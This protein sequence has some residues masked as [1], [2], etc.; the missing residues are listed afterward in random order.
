MITHRI[1]SNSVE[2]HDEVSRSINKNIEGSSSMNE[3]IKLFSAYS[4]VDDFENCRDVV[5][6]WFKCGSKFEGVDYKNLIEG[7][8][9]FN[10]QQRS[11][12]ESHVDEYFTESE[13]RL[14]KR[15]LKLEYDTELIIDDQVLPMKLLKEGKGDVFSYWAISS[16][17]NTYDLTRD[18][19]GDLPF[20]VSGFYN[21][22]LFFPSK[23]LPFTMKHAGL[24]FLWRA[25]DMLYPPR[26]EIDF[27]K[28]R[29]IV[30]E[31]YQGHNIYV[32]YNPC[33]AYPIRASKMKKGV[34]SYIP[35]FP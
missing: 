9:D 13:C 31:L 1:G 30:D 21:L 26:A 20:E 34:S 3:S 29:F 10:E 7:Y 2:Y 22:D 14:L 33:K 15:Y 19:P 6:H 8:E 27:D 23:E 24:V 12:C 5:I 4:I 17:S 25:L 18:K 35:T 11:L 32:N 28:L 16:A